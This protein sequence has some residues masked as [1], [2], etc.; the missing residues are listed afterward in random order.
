VGP[1]FTVDTRAPLIRYADIPHV[2]AIDALM[3][4]P[5][6]DEDLIPH[7]TRR[8]T[9]LLDSVV[10]NDGELSDS[11]DEGEGGRRNHASARDEDDAMATD[12]PASN[13][14]TR[15]TTGEPPVVA[16]L[17]T[18][19][20][21]TGILTP[22]TTQGAG[23]S[24]SGTAVHPVPSVPADGPE[25]MVTSPMDKTATPALPSIQDSSERAPLD[26][27]ASMEVDGAT[28]KPPSTTGLQVEATSTAASEG[29]TAAPTG[30]A[31]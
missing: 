29:N 21:P 27:D 30:T 22:S 1:N 20:A 15:S 10:Q 5:N 2:A 7:D 6:E 28:A 23:P 25:A 26:S 17:T 13:P 18:A 3:D 19:P 9:R 11:D 4:D 14:E 12:V 24:T 8:V 31:S 16:T